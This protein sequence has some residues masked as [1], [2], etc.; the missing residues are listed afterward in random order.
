MANAREK[1][2]KKRGCL[3]GRSFCQETPLITTQRQEKTRSKTKKEVLKTVSGS[4]LLEED[5]ANGMEKMSMANSET[6]MR[7]FM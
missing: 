1:A 5:K 7:D 2:K 3:M 4:T 6:M